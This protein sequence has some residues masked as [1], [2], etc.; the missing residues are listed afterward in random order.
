MQQ[1]DAM[2]AA[3][4]EGLILN[5]DVGHYLAG[6]SDDLLTVTRRENAG[7]RALPEFVTII[8]AGHALTCNTVAAQLHATG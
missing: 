6:R 5:C 1:L 7:R 4:G 3:G 2:V 8:F